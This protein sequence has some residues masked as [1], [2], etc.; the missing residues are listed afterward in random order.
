MNK[1][2]YYGTLGPACAKEEILVSMFEAGMTG[3]RLNLSHKSLEESREWVDLYQKVAKKCGKKGDLLIDLMGPEIRIGN[4]EAPMELKE[5]EKVLL[6]KDGIEIPYYIEETLEVG[7]TI[8]LDDGKIEL[9]VLK[10]DVGENRGRHTISCSVIR[11][12]ILKSRKSLAVPGVVIHNPTLTKED[13]K[14]LEDAKKYGVTAVMLPFVRGKE[15]LICLKNALKECGSEEIRIFA[16]IENMEGVEKLPE[17]LPHCDHIVIARGDLGNAVPLTS[18]PVIQQEISDLCKKEG[19]PFMVVT[20]M[21]NSM[22]ESPVPTRAEVTDI[23]HAIKE[24]ASSVMLT[25]ETAAGRY[26]V[27]AMRVLVDTGEAAL[28]WKRGKIG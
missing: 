10:N 8:L 16:K 1:I 19:M 20:Q 12:G 15:D 2:E 4:M 3:I 6:G 5:G 21:L 25:G 13:L 14:N 22:M 23:F 7:Q 9:V 11:G 28:T 17:L 18:L 26:P 24:G 27:E